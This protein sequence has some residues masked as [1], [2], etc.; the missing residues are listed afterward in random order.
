MN[1]NLVWLTL[2][3]KK[4]TIGATQLMKWYLILVGENGVIFLKETK[5]IQIICLFPK[6]VLVERKI[7]AKLNL[8]K[9]EKQID[10]II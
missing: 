9:I 7:V 2:Y 8:T 10:K 6:R 1:K 4:L 5:K 3:R